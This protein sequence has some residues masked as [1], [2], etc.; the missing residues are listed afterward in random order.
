MP[1]N[2]HPRDVCEAGSPAADAVSHE[3]DR[4]PIHP[5]REETEPDIIARLEMLDDVIFAAIEGDAVAI[6]MAADAWHA[7]LADLGPAAVDESRREYL[8]HAQTVWETLRH[9]P[10]HPPHKMFAAIEIISLLA[11]RDGFQHE[12]GR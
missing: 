8:R 12:G 6:E 11:G 5:H 4:P 10:D 7:A 1:D 2:K 3:S 9:Q